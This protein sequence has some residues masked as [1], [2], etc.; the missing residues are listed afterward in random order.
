MTIYPAF[1]LHQIVYLKTDVEQ[2]PRIVTAIK[3]TPGALVY[4][5]TQCSYIT[6]HYASEI[7]S[8]KDISLNTT[9]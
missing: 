4:E 6:G 5:L 9:N 8:E 3:I 2:K 1:E 7:N